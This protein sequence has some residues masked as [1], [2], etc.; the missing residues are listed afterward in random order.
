MVIEYRLSEKG[1]VSRGYSIQAMFPPLT[2]F[3]LID[4]RDRGRGKEKLAF[5]IPL[6]YTFIG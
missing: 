2:Q 6:I 4:F 1:E 5:V 3:L